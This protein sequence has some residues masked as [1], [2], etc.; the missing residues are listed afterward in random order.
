[1][2]FAPKC[3]NSQFFP[4]PAGQDCHGDAASWFGWIKVKIPDSTSCDEITIENTARL[5]SFQ[6]G[7]DTDNL[8]GNF[9][10]WEL[11]S[12]DT[13]HVTVRPPE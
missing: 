2:L 12:E 6:V 5:Q 9:T 1:M 3:L 7:A 8:D 11:D 13:S 10:A 4:V